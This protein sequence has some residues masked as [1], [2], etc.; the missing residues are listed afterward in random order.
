MAILAFAT[1]LAT[2][3][4]PVRDAQYWR[5]WQTTAQRVGL[6]RT[7]RAPADAPFTNADLIENFRQIIFYD[8]SVV[9]DGIYRQQ[10]APRNLEKFESDISYSV[11][12]EGV[13]E[14]DLAQIA[15]IVKR[16]SRATGLKIEEGEAEESEIRLMILNRAERK[17]LAA[18]LRE[19]TRM[20][21]LPN[22]LEADMVGNVCAA[23]PLEGRVIPVIYLIVIPDEVSGLLRHVCIEEEFAQ[24]FGPA[25]DY[26]EARPSIFND[27]HE[28]AFF[29]VHDERLFRVLYDPRL[30]N[31]MTEEQA[32]PI[33]RRIVEEYWPQD[34]KTSKG[35]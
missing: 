15:G 27:D 6:L 3:C 1:V 16:I 22:H 17:A 32:M 33:V 34:G 20:T 11:I 18:R 26:D 4:T 2:A 23:F 8:E 35:S 24:A 31:G 21:A 13:S 19:N 29:T 25:G 10:R 7:E 30:K 5:D 28:F 12:G 9:E 14:V